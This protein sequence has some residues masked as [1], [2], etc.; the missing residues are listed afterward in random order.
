M[1]DFFCKSSV[2]IVKSNVLNYANVGI[3]FVAN[4]DSCSNMFRRMSF[5][6]DG[7]GKE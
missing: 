6:F 5:I 4:D 3:Y 7:R 2:L 1:L